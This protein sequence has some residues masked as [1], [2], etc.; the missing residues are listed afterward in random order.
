MGPVNMM[1]LEEYNET[2]QRHV[3][4]EAQRK[5]L[6]DAIDDTQSSIKEIDDVSRAE[7]R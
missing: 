6:L 7:V 2:T 1:A 3:F 4:L 5:D